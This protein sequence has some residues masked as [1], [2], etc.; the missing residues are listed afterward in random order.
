MPE[1]LLRSQ[2]RVQFYMV[3]FWGEGGGMGR[4]DRAS[5]SRLDYIHNKINLA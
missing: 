5:K 4:C 1:E 2:G 3:L